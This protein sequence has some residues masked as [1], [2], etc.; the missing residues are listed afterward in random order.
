MKVK[1]ETV[2]VRLTPTTN[3]QLTE[4]VANLGI[5]KN[6]F[7]LNFINKELNKAHRRMNLNTNC[8]Q[9]E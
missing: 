4:H 7:I 9:T 5:S 1:K 2:S 6:A 8:K 3:K